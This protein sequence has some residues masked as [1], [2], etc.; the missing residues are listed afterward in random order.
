MH[1]EDTETAARTAIA[2]VWRRSHLAE[3]VTRLVI[4]PACEPG[5]CGPAQNSHKSPWE[6]EAGAELEALDVPVPPLEDTSFLLLLSKLSSLTSFTWASNRP[7]P[8]SLCP[9][10]GTTA[11]ALQSFTLDLTATQDRWDAPHLSLLPTTVTRL[12]L[13]QLSLEGVRSLATATAAL[14][15]IEHLRLSRTMFVEIG[16]AHV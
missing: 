16:R 8:A 7:P 4:A 10:L 12:D 2:A 13:S 6:C 15:A 14:P 5:V 1:A 3:S 9:A 11:K